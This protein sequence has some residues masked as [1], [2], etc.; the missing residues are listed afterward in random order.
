[1]F[2]GPPLAA[3]ARLTDKAR[4]FRRPSP[5][6]PRKIVAVTLAAARKSELVDGWARLGFAL[7]AHENALSL[8]DGVC[9]DF[10]APDDSAAGGVEDLQARAFLAHY[11]ARRSGAA[12]VGLSGEADAFLT[13]RPQPL[14]GAECYFQLIRAREP[15]APLHPN[16]AV[17][18][19]ALVAIAPDPG[20]FGEF[21]GNLTG[22]RAMVAT[23]AGL[24]IGLDGGRLD[25]LTPPA[26]AFRFGGAPPEASAFRI[27]GLHFAVNN[28]DE[29]ERF[30]RA[31]GLDVAARGGRLA[32]GTVE[33]VAVVFEQA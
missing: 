20:D 2:G 18:L 24:E 12:L 23:S 16:G 3:A 4:L 31:S 27:G 10:F 6:M 26:F 14:D 7:P 1:L 21:L 32:A 19:K 33:G 28:L 30:L 25:V 13:A 15:G 5:D 22:Q 11:A 17:A 8:A 9:L 29:T